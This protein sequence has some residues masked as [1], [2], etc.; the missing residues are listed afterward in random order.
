MSNRAYELG[1]NAFKKRKRRIP[2]YD[3]TLIKLIRGEVGENEKTFAQWLKGWDDAN[4]EKAKIKEIVREII[5]EI[6]TE[7]YSSTYRV[8]GNYVVNFFSDTRQQLGYLVANLNGGGI[9]AKIMNT[10]PHPGLKTLAIH[11]DDVGKALKFVEKLG[12]PSWENALRP[13]ERFR[14]G[15]RL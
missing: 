8:I 14:K 13:L 1:K 6:I 11:V 5:R 12:E 2:I 4:L 15:E 3:P 7:K 10:S 9:R